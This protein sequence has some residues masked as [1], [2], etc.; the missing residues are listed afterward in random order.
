M[1]RQLHNLDGIQTGDILVMSGS[2]PVQQMIKLITASKW[3]HVGIAVWV[4]ETSNTVLTDASGIA[5]NNQDRA[6]LM[7]F[8]SN[9]DP[10]YD[11]L[12]G[13]VKDGVRL[14]PI[15]HNIQYQERID[16]VHLNAERTPD[17]LER[18]YTFMLAKSHLSYE[19]SLFKLLTATLRFVIDTRKSSVFCS[20]LV[21]EYLFYMN[22]LS[23]AY[24]DQ[25]PASTYLPKDFA[26]PAIPSER[27][28]A[29][30]LALD[31]Y[32]IQSN[33]MYNIDNT[34]SLMIFYGVAFLVLVYGIFLYCKMN[35]LLSKRT[36][37]GIQKTDSDGIIPNSSES[38]VLS[39]N[40]ER[41]KP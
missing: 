39:S 6:R 33:I 27:V 29:A 30:I 8:E 19:P 14:I 38:N 9:N 31:P 22:I 32:P 24:E 2:L 18:F 34:P 16:V 35:G 15:E 3:N 13:Q 11:L 36:A 1:R 41:I 37:D 4:S 17:F 25:F 28:P 10:V 20:E 26:E 40:A 21:A 12:S 7:C 23:S 5:L